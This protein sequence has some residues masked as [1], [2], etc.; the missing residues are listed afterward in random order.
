MRQVLI[1][2]IRKVQTYTF[3][4]VDPYWG[5]SGVDSGNKEEATIKNLSGNQLL[6]RAFLEVKQ[7][8]E[9]KKLSIIARCYQTIVNLNY[10]H[11]HQDKITIP[12]KE[13][14]RMKRKNQEILQK[15]KK[16]L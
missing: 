13:R 10:Y 14:D 16:I 9:A 6:A 4:L 2:Y 7:L 5:N 11:H 1:F 15:A 12:S 3:N 8:L